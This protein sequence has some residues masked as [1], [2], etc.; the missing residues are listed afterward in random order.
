MKRW[1]GAQEASFLRAIFDALPGSVAYWDTEL[2][3]RFANAV[4]FD[5]HGKRPEAVLGT[6]YRDL[7][8]EQF[9]TPRT[10]WIILP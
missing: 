9:Y 2:F 5:W 10:L 8:N 6:H 1:A 4:F 7:V 3:C